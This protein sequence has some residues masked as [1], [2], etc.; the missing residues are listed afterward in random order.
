MN[1]RTL[2]SAQTV[3]L[4][5]VFPTIWI[6]MFVLGNLGLFLGAFH[7]PDNEPPPEA[8]KWSFLAFSSVG[9]AYLVWNCG[10]LKRVRADASAIYVSNYF[11]EIRVPFEAIADVTEKRW[12]NIHPVTIHLRSPTDFGDRIIFTPKI[13]I[14]A[15]QPHPVV[16][17]LRG[18]SASSC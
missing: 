16:G 14:R 7:G 15:W 10:R 17:E 5:F 3:W 6:S 1:E 11:K 13:R 18:L 12:N 9:T 8:L 4:K 2:S